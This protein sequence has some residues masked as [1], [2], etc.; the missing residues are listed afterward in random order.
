MMENPFRQLIDY[1]G[2]DGELWVQDPGDA[3]KKCIITGLAHAIPGVSRAAAQSWDDACS[4]AADVAYALFP[5][6]Q[7]HDHA[8]A[9]FNDHPDT[10]FADVEQV[11]EKCAV[12]Y[13]ESM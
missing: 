7:R 9:D 4:L 1:F 5:E 8:V 2:P 12:A 13:D 11:L 3:S 6:R 10:T